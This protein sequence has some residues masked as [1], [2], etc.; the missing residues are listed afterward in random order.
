MVAGLP[1]GRSGYPPYPCSWFADILLLVCLKGLSYST[2]AKKFIL[3]LL[4]LVLGDIKS[5]SE[6]VISKHV[7]CDN[8]NILKETFDHAGSN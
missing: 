3:V 7:G 4:S 1:G 2:K 8:Q 5:L 6:Q